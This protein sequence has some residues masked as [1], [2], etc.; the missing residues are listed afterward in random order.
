MGDNIVEAGRIGTETDDLDL[1][2]IDT[3]FENVSPFAD[4]DKPGVKSKGELTEV[5][6]RILGKHRIGLSREQLQGD[7]CCQPTDCTYHG[8][9]IAYLSID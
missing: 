3:S 2:G 4:A 8:R 5:S 1:S 9:K 7:L 6:A